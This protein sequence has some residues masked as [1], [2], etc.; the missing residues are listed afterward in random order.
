MLLTYVC[1]YV[2]IRVSSKHS[3]VQSIL[4][5]LN[6]C[7]TYKMAMLNIKCDS[8]FFITLTDILHCN[9]YLTI[10]TE[11]CVEMHVGL[12]GKCPL[13]LSINN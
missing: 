3:S 7:M 9:K 1:M 5:Y 11:R 8:L 12:Y 10:Y 2:C 6:N 4:C 13:F